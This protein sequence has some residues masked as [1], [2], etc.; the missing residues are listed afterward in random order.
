PLH[1]HYTQPT[2]PSL[3][4]ALY[5]LT[6][7]SPLHPHYTQPTTPSL[8]PAI[9][10]LTT[11]SHL[12]LSPHPALY[13]LTTPSITSSLHPVIYTLTTPPSHP[14]LHPAIYTLTTPQP[15]TPSLHPA[16]YTPHYTQLTTPSLPSHL[17]PSHTQHYT[18][19]PLHPHYTCSPY[20]P[21]YT[22]PSTPLTTPSHLHP[23]YT[24]PSTPSLLPALYTLTTPSP[25]HPSHMTLIP[26]PSHLASAFLHCVVFSMLMCR[27][28]GRVASVGVA[29]LLLFLLIF[30]IKDPRISFDDD[31]DVMIPLKSRH[32]H[33]QEVHR[34]EALHV[35]VGHYMGD[36]L[37]LAR[38]YKP[39]TRCHDK[40]FKV[41]RLPSTSVIIVFHNEAWSTLLRTVHSVINRSPPRLLEE[42]LLVDDASQRT[43]LKVISR[44]LGVVTPSIYL[45]LPPVSSHLPL[46]PVSSHL[47][48]PTC[49]SHLSPP[50]CPSH[51]FLSF[52]LLLS[53]TSWCPQEPLDEYVAKLPVSVRV[54]RS[55]VRTGLIRARLLGAQEARGTVLTFLDA[56]CEATT[57]IPHT[58]FHSMFHVNQRIYSL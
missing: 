30:L 8:H 49:P 31:P 38:H 20:T 44:S 7:P 39:N 52:T 11:P 48:P 34:Q 55:P 53:L 43:F 14:S 10:T 22:Q 18:L 36:N 1:P 45:S 50:T 27:R 28:R 12:H 9:Y 13:T 35:V 33:N 6:T 51:L 4:P 16:I 21:H 32:P 17:H 41:D 15:S 26:T 2:T 5:T 46:P 23:H 24:Q 54:I 29:A 37:Y 57:G 56:H 19:S 42:I 47:S 25:L 58:S 40:D 3:H